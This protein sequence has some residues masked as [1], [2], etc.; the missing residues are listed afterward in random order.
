MFDFRQ[1]KLF[2]LE[3]HLSMHKRLHVLKIFGG[4][5]PFGLPV[6]A[7]ELRDLRMRCIWKLDM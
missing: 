4:H 1:I 3:K 2:S 7:Y 6:Y 5:D